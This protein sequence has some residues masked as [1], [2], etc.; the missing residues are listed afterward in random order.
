MARKK[1]PAAHRDFRWYCLMSSPF[2][3]AALA[4]QGLDAQTTIPVT[5]MAGLRGAIN[6]ANANSGNYIITLAAGTY[7]ISGNGD[8]TNA[9]GDLDITK[10]AGTLE[11]VGTGAANVIIDGQALDRVFHLNNGANAPVTIR[12]LAITNGRATDN[13]TATTEARGGGILK[14]GAGGLT[15]N[16]VRVGSN[17]A[18]GADGANGANGGVGQNGGNGGTGMDARGGGMYVVSGTIQ[19]ISTT[20]TLNTV[21]AGDGG[22]GGRGGAASTTFGSSFGNGGNGGAGGLAYGGGVFLQGGSVA[23]SGSTLSQNATFA[24]DGGRGGTGA[25]TAIFTP[26]NGGAPGAAGS[27][28]GGGLYVQAGALTVTETTL[29]SNGANGGKGGNGGSAGLGLLAQGVGTDGAAGGDAYGGAICIESGTATFE[30][31]TANGNAANAGDGGVGGLGGSSIYFGGTG[32]TG[33]VGGNSRGGALYLQA[34][35]LD[36]VNSTVSGNFA[37]AGD[38]G[39]GGV[40]GEVAFAASGGVSP[41]DGGQGGNSGQSQGGGM[42]A[43]GGTLDVDNSTVASNTGVAGAAGAGGQPGIGGSNPGS[44]GPAGTVIQPQGGG[45]HN[46]GGTLTAESSIF[47]DNTANTGADFFGAGTLTS[48]LIETTPAGTGAPS[49]GFINGDPALSALANNG[50]PTNTH[51]I[52]GTSIA[53]NTGS[54]PRA[55]TTDQ[56]GNARNDG[57]GVDIGSFEDGSTP[58]VGQTQPPVVSAPAATVTLNAANYDIQGTAPAGSLVRIYSD[59]NDNGVVDGADAVVNSQQLG[60]AATGFSITVALAQNAANNFLATADDA[61]NTESTLVNVP[62]ITEDSL[63]PALPVV[64]APASAVSVSGTTYTIQGTAEA[65]SLVQ[66]YRDFNN[67]GIIDTG[68][69]VVVSSQQLTTGNS[70]FSILTGITVSTANDFLVTATDGAAN[71]SAPANVPTITENT[72]AAIN[73]PVVTN[74]A[75]PITVDLPAFNIQ[76]TA[77]ANALVRIYSDLNNDGFVNGTDTMVASE[78]LTGGNTS[79]SVSTVLAQGAANNFLATAFD[80]ANESLPTD[81]P[82]IT[83][84]IGISQG[85]G[86]GSGGGGGG[87]ATRTGT[88]WGLLALLALPIAWLRRRARA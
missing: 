59:A 65:G 26:G 28:R 49:S 17:I 25:G 31:S 85:G 16:G 67:N 23:L 44:V 7:S 8:N 42:Y 43:A 88:G 30:R 6:T 38:G 76:G 54:N 74:P 1:L 34:G 24:G 63:P 69:D 56:R 41:G 52:S 82:T 62:T 55:L 71:E 22:N 53:R 20:I 61:T 45:A 9:S 4:S 15:L 84:S 47:A 10:S 72:P 29:L 48:S 78:Q 79:F 32:E 12:D 57:N 40:G 81:V 18:R 19:L 64:T 60:G 2:I 50:G 5:D 21:Q 14:E 87:C 27:G 35:T 86:S 77:Q 46:G 3:A 68:S 33:G 66:V 75:T 36:V 39:T 80:G 13:G 70:N 11:I 58:P 83:D 51:A 37:R 73:P